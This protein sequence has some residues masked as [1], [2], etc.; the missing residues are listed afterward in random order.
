MASLVSLMILAGV[1]LWQ[2]VHA[3]HQAMEDGPDL[4]ALAQGLQRSG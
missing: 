2:R 3:G 1:Q 4:V